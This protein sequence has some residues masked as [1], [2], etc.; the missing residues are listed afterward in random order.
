VAVKRVDIS[1][2]VRLKDFIVIFL[3]VLKGIFK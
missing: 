1:L 3:A 2:L